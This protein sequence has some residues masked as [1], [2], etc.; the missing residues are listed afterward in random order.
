MPRK[1]TT[2][3]FINAANKIHSNKYD[4]SLTEYSHSHQKIKIICPVHG[5]FLQ[6][7]NDHKKGIGCYNCGIDKIK[8]TKSYSLEQFINI[9]NKV[10]NFE[11]DYSLVNYTSHN[12]KIKIICKKHGVFSQFAY[13]HIKGNKCK[14]CSHINQKHTLINN[15]TVNTDTWKYSTWI[16]KA[17]KSKTFDSFKCYIIKCWNDDEVFYKVGKTFRKL[18]DRFYKF[19]YSWEIVKVEIGGG[20]DISKLENK[21]KKLNKTFKYKPKI[22]FGGSYECFSE[23][24][25]LC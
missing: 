21:L 11:Y 22:N 9:V 18:E 19:Q 2:E 23:I 8:K 13:N 17:K 1:L 10:H 3:E 15:G 5:E 6:F 20:K 7:P 12:D 14:K 25:Y 16:D 4:Y 24:A